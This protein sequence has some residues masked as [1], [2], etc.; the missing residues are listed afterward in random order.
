[1]QAKSKGRKRA[2]L[3]TVTVHLAEGAQADKEPALLFAARQVEE[4]VADVRVQPLPF[5]P[6]WLL[7]LCVWRQ[8]T[9]PV[10]DAARLYGLDC[11][12][13]RV[14][15]MVVRAVVPERGGSPRQLLRCMLKVSSRIAAGSL[16]AACSAASA[17]A[18]GFDPAFVKG[19]FAHE[20][21]LL[22]VPDLLP[23]VC[24]GVVVG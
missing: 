5:A 9:L 18:G 16:P 10:I 4:V 6:D 20:D 17:E 13:E 21:G 2:D 8:Q 1:M 12:P 14:L 24:P 3:K 11:A 19:L 23:A 22:L 15:H 7:G